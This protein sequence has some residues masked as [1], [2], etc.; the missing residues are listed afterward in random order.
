[1]EWNSGKERRELLQPW[2]SSIMKVVGVGG[3]ACTRYF[4]GSGLGVLGEAKTEN[5]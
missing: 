1:M 2:A 3:G 4:A 5:N